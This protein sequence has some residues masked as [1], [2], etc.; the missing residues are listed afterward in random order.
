MCQ[1]HLGGTIDPHPFVDADGTTTTLDCFPVPYAAP[2]EG[3][4]VELAA[5][6]AAD[7]GAVAGKA[8]LYDVTLL[9]LPGD[10][11][12]GQG[13]IP[14]G[15]TPASRSDRVS[16]SFRISAARSCSLGRFRSVE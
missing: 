14:T 16:S 7:P 2:V 5:F 12:A 15:A 1:D 10:F 8:A 13:S 6:D 9:R 3:L 4:D 11:M